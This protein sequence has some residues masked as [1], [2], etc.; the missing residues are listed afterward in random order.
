MKN[1]GISYN[2]AYKEITKRLP[3]HK[4][5]AEEIQFT[6]DAFGSSYSPEEL[7]SSVS[8][9]R[10]ARHYGTPEERARQKKRT[11]WDLLGN[12]RK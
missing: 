7:E 1:Y 4:A 10:S 9:L 5:T 3:D 12:S 11:G 8:N 6:V 2:Q